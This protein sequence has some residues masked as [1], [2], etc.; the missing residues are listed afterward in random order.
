MNTMNYYNNK[1]IR[2]DDEEETPKELPENPDG[3]N[4]ERLAV[5][6]KIY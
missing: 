2:F 3:K 5:R 6:Q 4:D 1:Q